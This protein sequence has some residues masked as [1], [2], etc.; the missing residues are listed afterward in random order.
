MLLL[1]CDLFIRFKNSL[2]WSKRT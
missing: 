1:V 2:I